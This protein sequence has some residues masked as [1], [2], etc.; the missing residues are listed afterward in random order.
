MAEINDIIHDSKEID[1]FAG[2]ARNIL[3]DLNDILP[4]LLTM[5]NSNQNFVNISKEE[6]QLTHEGL[7]EIVAGL[8]NMKKAFEELVRCEDELKEAMPDPGIMAL[9]GLVENFIKSMEDDTDEKN[10]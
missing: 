9:L 2:A 4:N 5:I 1:K 10:D 7:L 3:K 6:K 8:L